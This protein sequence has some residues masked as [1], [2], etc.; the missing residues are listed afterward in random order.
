MRR[1]R[2]KSERACIIVAV[3][4][5]HR[6]PLMRERIAGLGDGVCRSVTLLFTRVYRDFRHA[7]V[8]ANGIT[9]CREL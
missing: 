9:G 3:H 6:E 8:F 5:V 2:K 7:I 1:M 4:Y